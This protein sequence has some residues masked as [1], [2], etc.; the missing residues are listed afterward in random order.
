MYTR[1]LHM[2][3][4]EHVSHRFL[5]SPTCDQTHEL[6]MLL[7]PSLPL[8]ASVHF[9]LPSSMFVI[10]FSGGRAPFSSVSLWIYSF[11]ERAESGFGMLIPAPHRQARQSNPAVSGQLLSSGKQMTPHAGVPGGACERSPRLQQQLSCWGC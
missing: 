8:Q 4:C 6:I 11:P 1:H 7:L 3:T 10:P 2:Y 9:S 5:H